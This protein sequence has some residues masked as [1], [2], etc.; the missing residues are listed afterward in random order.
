MSSEAS[1]RCTIVGLEGG[2]DSTWQLL[3]LARLA[4]RSADTATVASLLD[5]AMAAAHQP[6]DWAEVGWQL[7]WFLEPGEWEAWQ[8]IPDSARGPF[9]RDELARR[10]IRDG[11]RPGSRLVEHFNRL[12]Y[13]EE[14]FLR[15]MPRKMRGRMAIASTPEDGKAVEPDAL[16]FTN[17][18]ETVA[19]QP[20]RFY[21]PWNPA[22]DDRGSVWLR[23]GKPDKMVF[24]KDVVGYN[25]REA[26]LYEYGDRRLILNFE[27][28]LFDRSQEPTR[29]VAG[30]LGHYLCGID[31]S[32][33]Q[34]T[35]RL[36]CWEKPFT[37]DP[38]GTGYS[39]I[40][41]ERLEALRTEDKADIAIATTTDDNAVRVSHPIETEAH[42]SRVWDPA[43][44]APLAVIPYAFRAG[45]LVLTPDSTGVSAE[46]ELTL[47]Q[48]SR[49]TETWLATS[50]IRRLHYRG[51]PDDQSWLT[52]FVVIPSAPDVSA[53][54]LVAQQDT[55]H[56]GRAWVDSLGAIGDGALRLSDLVLG[57][58]IQGQRWITTTG[59]M[60]PLGSLGAFDRGEPVS[61][62]WQVRSTVPRDSVRTTMALYRVGARREEPAFR[63]AFGGRL[64][65]GLSEVRRDLGVDRLDGGEYRL[66][67]VVRDLV[68]G[69][70]A[71]RSAR[72]LVK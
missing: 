4:S 30:V 12:D 72:L 32:R 16:R 21:R 61:V 42:L 48:W 8:E 62:Y 55:A 58:D 22:L 20:F 9:V 41:P 39:P 2:G 7:R 38:A 60:V 46:F 13:A 18:P 68:T 43:T 19:A 71:R 65:A 28:E 14:H 1:N 34:L 64:G 17:L 51:T 63:V 66:E 56:R 59:N 47:R 3:H 70:E 37:C 26:W 10:D 29:L 54:S 40:S 50:I 24:W 25:T 36:S 69:V 52:S 33:C 44:G 31:N 57:A 67:L 6:S 35:M 27:G 45:D 11:R 23:L 15:D 53:W 5:A 49:A